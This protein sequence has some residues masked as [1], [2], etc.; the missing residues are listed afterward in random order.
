MNASDQPVTLRWF[1]SATVSLLIIVPAAVLAGVNW[2]DGRI[3]EH[4]RRPHL[5]AIERA[6][7]HEDL[8]DL[9]ERISE[10][11]QELR[12]LRQEIARD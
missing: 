12:L 7:Y 9:K 10:V 2:V 6:E 11:R 5:G 4:E 3:Q 8:V 1:L